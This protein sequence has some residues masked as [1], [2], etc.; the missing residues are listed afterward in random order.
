VKQ[1]A[2]TKDSQGSVNIYL[3]KV[4]LRRSSHIRVLQV[5]HG[6]YEAP[7]FSEGIDWGIYWLEVMGRRNTG[8][9]YQYPIEK[10]KT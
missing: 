1:F 6:P 2:H 5:F 9:T 10:V 4:S 3:N 7:M 8:K